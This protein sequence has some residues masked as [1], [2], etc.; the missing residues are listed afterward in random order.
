MGVGVHDKLL[1]RSEV[2]AERAG[3]IVPAVNVP[4]V[5]TTLSVWHSSMT[6]NP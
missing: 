3:N 5:L 2:C 6:S 4:M 1:K